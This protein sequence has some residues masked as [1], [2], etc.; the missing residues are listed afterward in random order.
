MSDG[1]I[2][3]ALRFI[4]PESHFHEIGMSHESWSVFANTAAN[5]K[6]QVRQALLRFRSYVH[7]FAVPDGLVILLPA[8]S[9]LDSDYLRSIMD[10]LEGARPGSVRIEMTQDVHAYVYRFCLTAQVWSSESAVPP[11]H[12]VPA[13]TQK[14][15]KEQ[16]REVIEI[17][18]HRRMRLRR[19][20]EH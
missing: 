9:Y 19:G 18:N 1:Y 5:A 4:I 11:P 17:I 12:P 14:H 6:P 15:I 7:T 3:D 10:F 20:E 16:A 13:P 8:F 2:D